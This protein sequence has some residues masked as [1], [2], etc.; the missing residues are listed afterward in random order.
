MKIEDLCKSA[1]IQAG[2]NIKYR[3]EKYKKKKIKIIKNLDYEII[4]LNIN[5]LLD[6][7]KKL[8][9][10]GKYKIITYEQQKKLENK[11]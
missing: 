5:I 10:K 1:I 4:L 8:D 6:E 3:L 7:I 2:N 11:R 9:K